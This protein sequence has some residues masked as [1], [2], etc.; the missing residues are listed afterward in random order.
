MV[1]IKSKVEQMTASLKAGG[2]LDIRRSVLG[3]LFQMV[4]PQTEKAR[5]LSCVR[6]RW[7]MAA[8][9]VVE[10]R[11]RRWRRWVPEGIEDNTKC[12]EFQ[13]LPRLLNENRGYRYHTLMNLVCA[14]CVTQR[15]SRSSATAER[16][17]VSYTRLSWPTHWS[18][19]SL[20]TASV[21]QTIY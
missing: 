14:H 21:L 13:I 6:V 8:R 1:L 2:T 3:R 11:H 20:S 7:T 12:N 17:R 10:R 15:Q 19:T 16:Q 5:W 9:D 4:G 18:C